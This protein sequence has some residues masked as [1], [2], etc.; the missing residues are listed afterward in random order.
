VPQPPLFTLS[1]PRNSTSDPPTVSLVVLSRQA[2]DPDRRCEQTNRPFANTCG[3]GG[4][5]SRFLGDRWAIADATPSKAGS[6]RR[7]RC[8]S[9]PA[10]PHGRTPAGQ[11]ARPSWRPYRGDAVQGRSRPPAGWSRLATAASDHCG[12]SQQPR[13]SVPG[14]IS[15]IGR[16]QLGSVGRAGS[17]GSRGKVSIDTRP[18]T[19]CCG[20]RWAGRSRSV[21]HQR[22]AALPNIRVAHLGLSAEPSDGTTHRRSRHARL[23]DP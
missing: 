15:A 14:R 13:S 6:V 2:G 8:W 10:G 21:D 22:G 20:T 7:R 4:L 3:E 18:G 17:A 1:N 9:T 12:L 11:P 16:P 23:C 5:R 19:S